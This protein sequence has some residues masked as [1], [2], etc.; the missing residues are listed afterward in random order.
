[1]SAYHYIALSQDGK[2]LSG[3]IEA[4]DELEARKK[5]NGL[6][7]SVVS[8]EPTNEVSVAPSHPTKTTFEFTAFDKNRKK[9][10]GTIAADDVAEAYSR[11][12]SQYQLD[13]TGLSSNGKEF[14]I[15]EIQET[16]EKLHSIEGVSSASG[17]KTAL[18]N[19]ET[20]ERTELLQK[21]DFTMVKIQEFLK[22]YGTDLKQDERETIQAYMNQL[23][24][25]KGS[26]NLEHI[27]MTCEKML[28]HVQRQELFIHEE[29]KMKE[30]THIKVET[31]E[32]LSSLKRTGLKQEISFASI[33]SKMQTI[34]FL[35]PLTDLLLKM[36][37]PQTT[38]IRQLK[39]EIKS[40]NRHM[41]EYVRILFTRNSV[42]R[43]EAWQTIQ[44]LF[45]EKKRLNLK[46][47]SLID[48][49]KKR[50]AVAEVPSRAE[51]H[52]KSGL[53]WVFGVYFLLYAITYPL[54]I[55]KVPFAF[56]GNLYFYQTT[57][58]KYMAIFCFFFYAAFQ[59]QHLFFPKA[60]AVKFV[61]Y[62]GTFL[63]YLLILINLM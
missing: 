22:L 24:R 62:P 61:L 15:T 27:R 9:V 20:L 55:K 6:G 46:L 26:T 21:V 33:V 60:K 32:M 41:W 23:I 17:E 40:V 2:E 18:S 57:L 4:P 29:Q 34:K 52:I 30:S 42:V 43:H 8:L 51:D 14:D 50:T 5:L 11:L 37:P 31:R 45:A 58:P 35:K 38:E 63:I 59:A 7:L 16:Y 13:V 28:D 48:E 53:G 3:I 19:A 10:V 39:D 54:T 36:A 44:T 12:F 25:I 56:P 49:E 1:M 47:N